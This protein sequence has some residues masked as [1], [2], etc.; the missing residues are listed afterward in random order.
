[1]EDLYLKE[2]DVADNET[3][4]NRAYNRYIARTTSINEIDN[5]KKNKS[6]RFYRNATNKRLETNLTNM[7]SDL[8]PFIVGIEN[9]TYFDLSNSQPVLFNIQLEKY[10]KDAS[11]ELLK[12]IDWYYGLTKD[13]QWYELL[14]K[15]FN[16]DDREVCKKNWMKIAYSKNDSYRHLKKVFKRALPEIYK[17]IENIKKKN[18]KNFAVGLQ[19]LESKIF[20]TKICSKLVEVG[21]IPYTLHDGLLVLDEYADETLKIMESVLTECLGFTPTIKE[22]RIIPFNK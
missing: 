11:P 1:V 7:A 14:M 2:S 9:M 22:E 6:L 21:I 16:T 10:K 5:G 18:Y 19:T 4:I 3:E 13:G 8:R 17:V 12:E 20:I 15:I